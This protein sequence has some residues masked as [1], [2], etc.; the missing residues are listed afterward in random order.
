[1]LSRCFAS[2]AVTSHFSLELETITGAAKLNLKLMKTICNIGTTRQHE[3]FDIFNRKKYLSNWIL[4]ILKMIVN[5][6]SVVV[7][8]T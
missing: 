1:M 4:Q 3:K 5:I 2:D 6:L 8:F 7:M